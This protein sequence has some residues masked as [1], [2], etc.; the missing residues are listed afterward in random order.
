MRIITITSLLLISLFLVSCG[1][2]KMNHTA[3]FETNQGTFEIELF[4]DKMPVTTKNFIKLVEQGFY[5]Q[6]KFHRVISNFMIQGGDPLSADDSKKASWGTGGPGYN[7]KDEFHSELK[8]L[9]GTIAM[10]NAGPNTG[11]S[12]FFINLV[13]NDYLDSKHPVFGQVIQGQEVVEKIGQTQTNPFDQ[14]LQ[15]V[16]IKK[17]IIK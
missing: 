16:V 4:E 10:A 2:N 6:T 1:G 12:Q 11:G 3:V 13:S 9:K 8:N 7:I 15:T 14:P 5:D 17:I